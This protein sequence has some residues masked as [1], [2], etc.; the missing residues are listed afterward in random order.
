VLAET[1]EEAATL[2]KGKSPISVKHKLAGRKELKLIVY[3][4]GSLMIK[5]IKNFW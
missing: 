3:Q 1:A 4:T 5:F 2:I